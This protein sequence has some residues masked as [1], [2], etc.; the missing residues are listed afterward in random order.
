MLSQK[1]EIAEL[2]RI[3]I[4]STCTYGALHIHNEKNR[5]AYVR[6]MS[7]CL[8][9]CVDKTNRNDV[10]RMRTELLK[11][12]KDAIKNLKP[13]WELFSNTNRY[14]MFGIGQALD[15]VE[16]INTRFEKGYSHN[17]SYFVRSIL[18]GNCGL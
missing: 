16:S 9:I 14:Y 3:L 15:A 10:S 2:A 1:K 12:K 18:G 5:F 17:D 13:R 4:D 11:I 7:R 6:A 8:S